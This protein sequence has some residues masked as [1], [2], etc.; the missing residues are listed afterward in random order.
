MSSRMNYRQKHPSSEVASSTGHLGLSAI[1]SRRI[2]VLSR[3][4]NFAAAMIQSD[5]GIVNGLLAENANTTGKQLRR[6]GWSEQEE[7]RWLRWAAL[8]LNGG[9]RIVDSG[10]RTGVELVERSSTMW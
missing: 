9:R 6:R 1:Y 3:Q 8:A 2:Q 10:T 5:E 4:V 7:R